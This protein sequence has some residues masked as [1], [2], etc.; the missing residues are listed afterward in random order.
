MPKVLLIEDDNF[1]SRMYSRVF[2][3]KG[4]EVETAENA[5]VGLAKA[6]SFKPDIIFLDVMLPDE[7][8]LELLKK[9]KKTEVTKNMAVV[10]LTNLGIQ[11][12]LDRALE[13]GAS[14]YIIKN[15]R[16]PSEILLIAQEVLAENSH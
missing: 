8:G 2:S 3:Y 15:D 9:L 5:K 6:K 1:L 7:N 4:Y 12:E 10:L 11:K 14:R 13:S 16:D